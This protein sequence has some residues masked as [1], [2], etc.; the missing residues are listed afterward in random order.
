MLESLIQKGNMNE[1][2]NL[3]GIE[4]L[5]QKTKERIRRTYT[6]DKLE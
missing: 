2:V 3:K 4:G 1:M 5:I 6:E